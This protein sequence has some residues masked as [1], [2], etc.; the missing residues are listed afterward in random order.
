MSMVQLRASSAAAKRHGVLFDNGNG[1]TDGTALDTNRWVTQGTSTGGTATY[2]SNGLKFS[3]GAAGAYSGAA[4]ITRNF[5]ITDRTDIEVFGTF[6]TDA[7]EP[8]GEVYARATMSTVDVSNGY[9][10]RLDAIGTTY[11]IEKVVS[12]SGTGIGTATKTINASTTYGFRFRV[13]GTSLKARVWTGTEPSSWDIDITDSTFTAAGK[14]GLSVGAG[15][16]A[17]N[18]VITFDDITVASP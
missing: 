11:T 1:Q 14:S 13:V 15:N 8:Y 6:T 7:N 17:V 3:T 4:R 16:A 12:F 18:H 10:L 2:Q 5:N 9:T